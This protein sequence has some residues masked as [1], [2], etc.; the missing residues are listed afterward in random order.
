MSAIPLL[1]LMHGESEDYLLI[2]DALRHLCVVGY[3]S[4]ANTLC[5]RSEK[6]VKNEAANEK[7]EEGKIGVNPGTN[8]PK[9]S[10]KSR[11]SLR[12]TYSRG[13]SSML[14][15]EDP[16]R[17][18]NAAK[19]HGN[20]AESALVDFFEIAFQGRGKSMTVDET[21]MVF[22]KD[23]GVVY[24]LMETVDDMLNKFEGLDDRTPGSESYNILVQS[25]TPLLT[26]ILQVIKCFTKVQS[27]KNYLA[28]PELNLI[29]LLGS[30]LTSFTEISDDVTSNTLACMENLSKYVTLS[31]PLSTE[32]RAG[33]DDNAYFGEQDAM[34]F[35]KAMFMVCLDHIK[36]D[37]DMQTRAYACLVSLAAKSDDNCAFLI[38]PHLLRRDRSTS[39]GTKEI[40]GIRDTLKSKRSRVSSRSKDS[41]LVASIN[42]SRLVSTRN[43]HS[44]RENSKNMSS[45]I[46]NAVK[47]V[48]QTAILE[49]DESDEEHDAKDLVYE[50]QDCIDTVMEEVVVEKDGVTSVLTLS[51]TI[52]HFFITGQ[53]LRSRKNNMFSVFE[54]L[55]S[56]ARCDYYTVGETLYLSPIPRQ[57]LE[58]I[59]YMP[60]SEQSAKAMTVLATFA[61]NP[62][63]Q[64]RILQTSKALNLLPIC[65]ST[66]VEGNTY[67]KNATL[68]L[69]INITSSVSERHE[70]FTSHSTKTSGINYAIDDIKNYLSMIYR[71]SKDLATAMLRPEL[72]LVRQVLGL[73]RNKEVVELQ[74]KDDTPDA[75][76]KGSSINSL[77]RER[78]TTLLSYLMV[79]ALDGYLP[80]EA[81][82]DVDLG[83]MGLIDLLD[84]E[85]GGY[86]VSLRRKGEGEEGGQE[87]GT[88]DISEGNSSSG[89]PNRFSILREILPSFK[90]EFF[91][92]NGPGGAV[93]QPFDLQDPHRVARAKQS[94]RGSVTGN[95]P[96]IEPPNNEVLSA[97][98][99][100]AVL[101]T[102]Q[103]S[104][105]ALTSW[106]GMMMIL[107]VLYDK[108]SMHASSPEG[109]CRELVV[110]ILLS[111]LTIPRFPGHV[112][113]SNAS[114]ARSDFI[115]YVR[116]MGIEGVLLQVLQKDKGS[117]SRTKGSVGL[118]ML[119]GSDPAGIEVRVTELLEGVRGQ[120][121]GQGQARDRASKVDTSRT[122]RSA[123]EEEADRL[124]GLLDDLVSDVHAFVLATATAKRFVLDEGA[125][126]LLQA[127]KEWAAAAPVSSRYCDTGDESASA[128]SHPSTGYPR[129]S[130]SFP[131]RVSSQGL[132]NVGRP[133]IA[134]D[135][136]VKDVKTDSATVY[137]EFESEWDDEGRYLT[138]AIIE[139]E[140]RGIPVITIFAAILEVAKGEA[141]G[142]WLSRPRFVGAIVDFMLYCYEMR[143]NEG[144]TEDPSDL[145]EK[146]NM[147]GKRGVATLVPKTN[148]AD[149]LLGLGSLEAERG[150]WMLAEALLL[151]SRSSFEF[152]SAPFTLLSQWFPGKRGEAKA[153]ALCSRLKAAWLDLRTSAVLDPV[154]ERRRRLCGLLFKLITDSLND[155]CFVSRDAIREA[156]DSFLVAN[157]HL[158]LL[159]IR[160][161]SSLVNPGD[162][163]GDE[164]GEG[165]QVGSSPSSSPGARTRTTSSSAP[166]LHI[167]FS[168]SLQA[169]AL[170]SLVKTFSENLGTMLDGEV[171]TYGTGSSRAGPTNSL[172]KTRAEALREAEQELYTKDERLLR[173]DAVRHA[174]DCSQ[175]IVIALSEEYQSCPLLREEAEYAI[176]LSKL[177]CA[178]VL[179]LCTQ[180]YYCPYYDKDPEEEGL[181]QARRT[182]KAGRASVLAAGEPCTMR[183]ATLAAQ[184]LLPTDPRLGPGLA[185]LFHYF[186]PP[187]KPH[188]S[189][190]GWL[191][192]ALTHGGTWFALWSEREA[193]LLPAYVLAHT[194]KGLSGA[195]IAT[196][197]YSPHLFQ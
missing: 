147:P 141:N 184:A 85:I 131:P 115:G 142:G 193:E 53:L 26:S 30:I 97:L 194:R 98:R 156:E 82:V 70:V 109:I 104:A 80:R 176:T 150:F 112:L 29:P 42:R 149:E 77:L 164:M 190:R 133:W 13:K 28:S 180:P 185:D 140:G 34:G 163:D 6:Q 2:L 71:Y 92:Y 11:K 125:E 64:L 5:L 54:A 116:S 8:L 44:S 67:A 101:A 118:M 41:R 173:S 127:R 56:L 135:V 1:K 108:R 9:S 105:E 48:N 103:N 63:V 58:I 23:I 179:F 96:V 158:P 159:R 196:V 27:A 12:K 126:G 152:H 166:P 174:M 144:G 119:L 102:D 7:K 111:L 165:T 189:L 177:G 50:M 90:C 172:E 148:R 124:V 61:N 100:V 161:R 47:N 51:S 55:L 39:M 181:Q 170:P 21:I 52:L 84:H 43:R 87:K 57:L 31:R 18:R 66:L 168:Y 45:N 36:Y 35:L 136:V 129:P 78:C 191:S 120:G 37:A 169:R 138:A 154:G 10:P 188:R 143:T 89:D 38:D 146:K 32:I 192:R 123:A 20:K 3:K 91:H 79:A 88:D 19:E 22:V 187:I 162:E 178:K 65:V 183:T 130:H 49:E 25:I 134:A 106:P 139:E 86:V 83:K 195:I 182:L 132:P 160:T 74:S 75:E 122:G 114:A 69:L 153:K 128:P 167:T 14:I 59:A 60:A 17:L 94:R 46:K 62:W 107:S 137:R 110:N 15:F 117:Q 99:L 197:P 93:T 76:G 157:S 40:K 171:W 73:F 155:T 81:Y 33:Y 4:F 68:L 175:L 24:F 95:M 186:M 72:G 151:L 16:D 113:S 145:R 121:Q